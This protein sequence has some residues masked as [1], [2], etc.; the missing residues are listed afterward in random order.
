MKLVNIGFG[1]FISLNRLVG[2]FEIDSA[3][4]KRLV[5]L[6]KEKNIL[7]DAT[8]GRKTQ[9]I[10]IMDTGNIVLSALNTE[11]ISSKINE[12]ENNLT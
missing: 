1:N 3:P 9:S 6:G 5:H 4:S 12:E 2:I 11:V 7:I 8:C 10:L